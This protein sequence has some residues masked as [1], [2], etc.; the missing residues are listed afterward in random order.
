[1]ENL[2]LMQQCQAIRLLALDVDGV[3]TDESLFYTEHGDFK[4]FNAKDGLALRLLVD[5]N[6]HV[7]IVTGRKSQAV[8]KR[9]A[10]LKIT[11]ILEGVENK[12]IALENLQKKWGLPWKNIAFMGDDLIDLPAFK[13][14]GLK[15]APQNACE[16]VLNIADWVSSK[17]GGKGAVRQAAELLLKAQ[18]I[19]QNWVQH[20]E[21]Q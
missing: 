15:L 2:T 6:I 17:P 1:M 12:R 5:S 19:W 20:F 13:C 9:M 10:E 8:C 4:C 7:A 18:G 21:N 11:D 3:L 14:C 16:E